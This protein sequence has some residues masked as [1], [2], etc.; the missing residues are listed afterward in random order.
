MTDQEK[1]DLHT[2]TITNH[3]KYVQEMCDLMGIHEIGLHHD[4][5]KFYDDEFDIY[6]WATG[7]KSP[8]DVARDELGYSPSWVHHKARNQHH[9]EYWT[10]F[11]EATPNGDGTF[12]ITCKCVKMPYDR[13]I[14]MFCDFVGAG[15]AYSKEKW[16]PETPWNYWED[17]CEGKRAMHKES[18]YLI[19]KLLWNLHE[20]GLDHFI[21]WYNNIK[22]Y[23]QVQYDADILSDESFEEN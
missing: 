22:E 10:D 17:K 8:H 16:T 4:E 14:E 12:T 19:K 15:K 5:S 1:K 18:E 3:I 20:Y 9:W 21:E 6:H 7:E 23:L 13:V 2:E 11:N